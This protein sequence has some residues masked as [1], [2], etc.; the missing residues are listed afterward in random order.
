MGFQ[1]WLFKGLKKNREGTHK[2]LYS[3]KILIVTVLYTNLYVKHLFVTTHI[4]T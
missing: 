2:K 4:N 3:T 1:S